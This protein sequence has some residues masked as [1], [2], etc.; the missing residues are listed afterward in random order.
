M[1]RALFNLCVMLL[2]AGSTSIT[3]ARTMH[4]QM[5]PRTVTSTC[6]ASSTG[7]SLGCSF[8]SFIYRVTAQYEDG[9]DKSLPGTPIAARFEVITVTVENLPDGDAVNIRLKITGCSFNLNSHIQVR[10]LNSTGFAIGEPVSF[11]IS[12]NPAML[13][14]EQSG[15]YLNLGTNFSEIKNIEFSPEQY[16]V[17]IYTKSE[18]WQ[19]SPIESPCDDRYQPKR[20]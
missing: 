14:N 18:A 17:G 15:R 13:H 3:H 10:F 1:I 8:P 2:L 5:E 19:R 11:P 4:A 6:Q 16:P 20:Q 9:Q 7:N 12:I